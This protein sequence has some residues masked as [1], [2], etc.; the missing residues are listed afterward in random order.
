MKW[1]DKNKNM[2]NDDAAEEK[3]DTVEA[4]NSDTVDNAAVMNNGSD[5]FLG[6][7]DTVTIEPSV[8]ETGSAS[9]FVDID[10]TTH[11]GEVIAR[12]TT[13]I[14][15]DSV[16]NGDIQTGD[17]LIIYG[18][19]LGNVTSTSNVTVFGNVEGTI[20]CENA[21]L[22]NATIHGDIDCKGK[23]DVSEATVVHGNVQTDVLMSGGKIKGNVSVNDA[24]CFTSTAVII[25][26]VQC[27]ELQVEQGACMQG[28]VAITKSIEI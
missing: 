8:E 21:I 6:N 27:K 13:T 19:I 14:H 17:D 7:A 18:K 22:K 20:I 5:D 16:I 28:N 1:Y 4:T 10:T 3:N 15:E 2:F 12:N 25:G 24:L 11:Q 9:A 23:M 26:D